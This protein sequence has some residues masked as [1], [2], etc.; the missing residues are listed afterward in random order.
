MSTG[1]V[2]VRVVSC[3]NHQKLTV[4]VGNKYLGG[5]HVPRVHDAH[6]FSLQ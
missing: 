3:F 5:D 6:D 2:P 4:G 1:N